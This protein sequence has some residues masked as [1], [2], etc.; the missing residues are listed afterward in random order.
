MR[1][2]RWIGIYG[3]CF[4]VIVI[5]R[6]GLW[7]TKYQRIRAVLVRPCRPDLQADRI[8]TVARVVRAVSRSAR[9]FPDASCLTQSIATQAILSWKHIP[10]TI[11]M[12]VLKDDQ[13]AF[14]VHAWVMW[15]G[16]VVLAGDEESVRDFSKIL[17]LPTPEVSPIS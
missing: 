3:L 12:G 1:S 4:A 16:S 14:R 2:L 9:F 15:N 10:T 6:I 8:H 17:D 13:G 11:S 7:V 5:V